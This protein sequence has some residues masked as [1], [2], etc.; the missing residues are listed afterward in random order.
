[1]LLEKKINKLNLERFF[2]MKILKKKSLGI[3]EV[4]LIF[5]ACL[6]AGFITYKAGIYA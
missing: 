1:M 5:L 3:F 6:Y 2:N 4:Y